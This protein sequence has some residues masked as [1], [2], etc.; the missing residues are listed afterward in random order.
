MSGFDEYYN[1]EELPEKFIKDLGLLKVELKK[2]I[3]RW[4]DN[5]EVVTDHWPEKNSVRL[6]FKNLSLNELAVVDE[7]LQKLLKKHKL[8]YELTSSGFL[9]FDEE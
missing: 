1:L 2:R 7:K 4:D 3:P 6:H 9:A 5:I 8:K